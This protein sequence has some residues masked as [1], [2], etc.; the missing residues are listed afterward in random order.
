MTNSLTSNATST[1]SS[2]EIV[3]CVLVCVSEA[4]GAEESDRKIS[5]ASPMQAA[6]LVRTGAVRVMLW[7]AMRGEKSVST[8]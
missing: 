3:E 4:I 6:L 7:M 8:A 2:P 1:A 5:R